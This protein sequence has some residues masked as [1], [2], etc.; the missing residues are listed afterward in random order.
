[1]ERTL[2][3][4]WTKLGNPRDNN[5][6]KLVYYP[7]Y[8]RVV[9]KMSGRTLRKTP[10]AI[11]FPKTLAYKLGMDGDKLLLSDEITTK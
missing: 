6:M 10:L 4:V 1:M 7:D 9:Y 3:K 11:H 5:D 8:D 2:K